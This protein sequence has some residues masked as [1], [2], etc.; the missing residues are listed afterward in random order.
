MR[1]KRKSPWRKVINLCGMKFGKLRVIALTGRKTDKGELYRCECDCG[2]ITT[3]P[4]TYLINGHTKS[5]GCEQIE[6]RHHRFIDKDGF[7]H[8]IP[9]Y[10]GRLHGKKI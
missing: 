2:N 8:M 6:S 1:N 5:C 10:G 7:E 3:V 4:R 9:N